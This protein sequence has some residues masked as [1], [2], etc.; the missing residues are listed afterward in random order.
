MLNRV[1]ERTYSLWGYIANHMNEYLNPLYR[2][3]TNVGFIQPN[4]AP[5]T[6]K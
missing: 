5:Q 3:E 2:P 6:F 1:K 4:I